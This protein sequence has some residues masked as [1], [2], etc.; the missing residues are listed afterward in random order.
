MKK[1]RIIVNYSILPG[2]SYSYDTIFYNIPDDHVLKLIL[3][4]HAASLL[5]KG[6]QYSQDKLSKERDRIDQLLKDKG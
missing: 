6:D 3:K 1:K 4:N 2:L 5:K